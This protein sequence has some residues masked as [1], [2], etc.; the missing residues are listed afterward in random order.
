[1][2]RKVTHSLKEFW[3]IEYQAQLRVKIPFLEYF[4]SMAFGGLYFVS[5]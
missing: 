4:I 1:M 5:C 3:T 2:E